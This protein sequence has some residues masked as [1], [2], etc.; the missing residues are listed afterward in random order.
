ML[1]PTPTTYPISSRAVPMPAA[2]L[3]EAQV[4]ANHPGHVVAEAGGGALVVAESRRCVLLLHRDY[5]AHIFVPFADVRMDLLQEARP[6]EVAPYADCAGIRFWHVPAADGGHVPFG[7]WSYD[8]GGVGSSGGGDGTG[9]PARPELAGRLTFAFHGLDR[10]VI[11]GRHERAHVRDP[12]TVFT[13]T[14]LGRHLVA[15]VGGQVVVDSRAALRLTESDYQDRY[16]VP[17]ADIAMDLLV[18]SDRVTVCAYKGEARYH[19]LKIGDRVWENAF[20]DYPQP[21]TDYADCFARIRGHHGF[22]TT[23]LETTL[24]GRPDVPDQQA[25]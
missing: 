21:W 9:V 23:M 16:Y 18:P 15:G 13:V 20:W 2:R 19:H 1:F 25:A 4:M 11:D 14:P 5:F 7:A 3:A 17:E 10:Y 6:D 24:D 12:R 22:F 8:F